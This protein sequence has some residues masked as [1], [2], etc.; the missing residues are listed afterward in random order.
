MGVLES[1]NV[2]EK[3][4][5]C[6]MRQP[7]RVWARIT[8]VAPAAGAV[9]FSYALCSVAV[10]LAGGE[11]KAEDSNKKLTAGAIE[12]VLFQICKSPLLK[13][14]TLPLREDTHSR[15]G[16]THFQ[17]IAL[18]ENRII[19]TSSSDNGFIRFVEKDDNGNF[20]FKDQPDGNRYSHPGGIQTI[21]DWAVVPVAGNG[22]S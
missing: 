7:M 5:V 6:E 3:F 10:T 17:G 8:K 22:T 18:R 13:R 21:G 1:T 16:D 9:V 20:H 2:C 12:K 15:W 4:L 11:F 19:V 14:I